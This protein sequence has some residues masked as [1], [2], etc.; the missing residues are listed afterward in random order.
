[1]FMIGFT[2]KGSCITNKNTK[3]ILKIF[4]KFSF[5]KISEDKWKSIIK[6]IRRQK[7]IYRLF[8][9]SKIKKIFVYFPSPKLHLYCSHLC[10]FIDNTA[11]F[12][13]RIQ[14]FTAWVA[15]VVILTVGYNR[16]G[17]AYVLYK[18]F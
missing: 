14:S 6:D 2:V 12:F 8:L 13:Q 17:R 15:V 3:E 11:V 16:I 10:R 1:M 9:C 18:R 4:D 5:V 7:T